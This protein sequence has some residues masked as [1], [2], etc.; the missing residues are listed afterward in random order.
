MNLLLT[1]ISVSSIVLFALDSSNNCLCL[2]SARLGES[3]SHV[4]GVSASGGLQASASASA[5]ASGGQ[6]LELEQK[7]KKKI[8]RASCRERVWR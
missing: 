7:N 2:N 6:I 1:I 5:S 3:Q 8:G 4:G